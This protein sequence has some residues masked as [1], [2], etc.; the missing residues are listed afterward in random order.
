MQA[1]IIAVS[2][3]GVVGAAAEGTVLRMED[4]GRS[5]TYPS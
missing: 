1:R 4:C 5:R 3:G 2:H